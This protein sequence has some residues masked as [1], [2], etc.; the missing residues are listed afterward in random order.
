MHTFILQDWTTIR[1][2]TAGGSVV[3][4][5]ES[6]LDLSAFQDLFFWVD[7]RE[8]TGTVTLFFDTSPTAD[9]SLFQPLVAGGQALTASTTPTLVRAP[10]TSASVPVARYVRWRASGSGANPWDATFRVVLAANSPGM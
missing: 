7:V 1:A 6:W 8:V 10:M 5:E 2:N 9:E 4:S 3:Q